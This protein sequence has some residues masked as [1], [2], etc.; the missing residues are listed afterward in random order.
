M[1]NKESETD[2]ARKIKQHLN[3]HLNIHQRHLRKMSTLISCAPKA[4]AIHKIGAFLCGPII[5]K[6]PLIVN[7]YF[8]RSVHCKLDPFLQQVTV[9]NPSKAALLIKRI[10]DQNESLQYL[11]FSKIQNENKGTSKI[12]AE[13]TKAFVKNALHNNFHCKAEK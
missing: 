10:L 4:S 6:A 2:N 8:K 7:I 3:Q 1:Y 12:I 11:F 13:S 9:D 5:L